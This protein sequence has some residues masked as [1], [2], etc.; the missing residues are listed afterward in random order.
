[1]K[2]SFRV[3]RYPIK[4]EI[5]S[6]CEPTKRSACGVQTVDH[7]SFSSFCE[8]R[9]DKVVKTAF[10][11]K[12]VGLPEQC[13]RWHYCGAPGEQTWRGANPA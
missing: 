13:R 11:R 9:C 1:M 12:E 10:P 4:P 3:H 6:D 7:I 2:T 8:Y 5:N